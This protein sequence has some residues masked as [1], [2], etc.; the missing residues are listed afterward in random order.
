[1]TTTQTPTEPIHVNPQEAMRFAN[2][3]TFKGNRTFGQTIS[4]VVGDQ[5]GHGVKTITFEKKAHI[6]AYQH[7]LKNIH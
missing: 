6:D 3:L 4:N 5:I 1:M 7:Y 2:H